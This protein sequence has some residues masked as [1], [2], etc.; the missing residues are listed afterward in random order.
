MIP[1][2]KQPDE[3]LDENNAV[4]MEEMLSQIKDLETEEKHLDED[5]KHKEALLDKIKSQ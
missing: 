1:D 4:Q 3:V 2:E 5:M